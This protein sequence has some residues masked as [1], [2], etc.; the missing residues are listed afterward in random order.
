MFVESSLFEAQQIQTEKDSLI[1]LLQLAKQYLRQRSSLQKKQEALLCSHQEDEFIKSL[2]SAIRELAANIDKQADEKKSIKK[3]AQ[4][5]FW[6]RI[7]QQIRFFFTFSKR[8]L[9]F[10]S[11]FTIYRH[12]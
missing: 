11:H 7:F 5:F 2:L 1:Q 12:I 4:E 9:E 10:K 6:A 8:S 3:H